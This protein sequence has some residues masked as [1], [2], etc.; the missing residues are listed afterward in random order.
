MRRLTILL[1][2]A[3]LT[4]L[5]APKVNVGVESQ[6]VSVGEPFLFQIRVSD[7]QSSAPPVLPETPDFQVQ[8]LQP[9]RNS[10]TSVSIINGQM[11]KTVIDD[12]LYNFQLT[13][14][15]TGMLS[16]PAVAVKADGKTWHT[17]PIPIRVHEAEKVTGIELELELSERV[18][19]VGQPVMATW[20]W[21]V[22][23]EARGYLFSLPLLSHPD[24]TYPP[25]EPKI[26]QQLRNSYLG[27]PYG[28]GQELIGTRSIVSRD[29]IRTTCVTFRR[30][31][32]PAKAGNYDLAAGTV[33]CNINDTRRARRR[34]QRDSFFDDFFQTTPTRRVTI[35]GNSA[36]LEVRPLPKQG[37]P[38]DFSGIIGRCSLRV[39]AKPTEVNVGDPIILTISLEG[40]AY[41]DGAHLPE[42][43]AQ[44][45]LSGAFRISDQ[46]SGVVKGNAKVFQCTLRAQKADLKEIPALR[47]SCFDAQAGEYRDVTSAPIP[48]TVHEVKTVTAADA[49]GFAP[50]A[51]ETAGA[52]VKAYD[53]GI[54]HN[55]AWERML[56]DER[57]GFGSWNRHSWKPWLLATCAL[58][59]VLTALTAWLVRRHNADPV[60]LA[61]RQAAHDSWQLLTSSRELTAE[62]LSTVFQ[63]YLRAQL[64]LSPGAVTFADVEKPLR[65]RRISPENLQQ[66]QSVFQECDAIRFAGGNVDTR[67]LREHIRTA[68]SSIAK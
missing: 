36:K 17:K 62:Q 50:L 43:S 46:D 56:V 68:L 13:P 55:Y 23:Q 18:C 67:T 29:G 66:I 19:Y 16:I 34:P 51:G 1:L 11:K 2:L 3:S 7:A 54:A 45:S 44:P 15:R 47:L 33:S 40:L 8:T 12:V 65:R 28:D 30:P 39:Q 24:F 37:R 58:L 25:Y 5:A 26:D 61:A 27:I 32:I 48:I 20:R 9:G 21:Y 22:S 10:S 52:E 59:Y 14:K 63:D 64:R 53:S 41:P 6:E 4:I 31:V 38:A 57:A 60:A 35:A 49:Q 42:I